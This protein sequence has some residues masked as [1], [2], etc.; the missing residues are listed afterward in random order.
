[1]LEEKHAIHNVIHNHLVS[2][3]FNSQFCMD[4]LFVIAIGMSWEPFAF[5]YVSQSVCVCEI[6]PQVIFY[7]FKIYYTLTK[8]VW[9]YRLHNILELYVLRK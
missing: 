5:L 9:E 1:M 6:N 8:R 3:K 2:N 7:I 4:T